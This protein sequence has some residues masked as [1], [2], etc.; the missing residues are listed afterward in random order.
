VCDKKKPQRPKHSE[1]L[2]GSFLP[3]AAPYLQFKF[4]VCVQKF[5]GPLLLAVAFEKQLEFCGSVSCETEA[6]FRKRV[7]LLLPLL[8][9]ASILLSAAA[10]VAACCLLRRRMR[11][12]RR[13]GGSRGL[14]ITNSC[15]LLIA[16]KCPKHLSSSHNHP[17]C[18]TSKPTRHLPF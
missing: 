5:H 3:F 17:S 7:Q 1:P 9:A 4:C 14:L 6:F 11:M 13:R 12:R 16:I 10:A 18:S 8:A 2:S 15:R